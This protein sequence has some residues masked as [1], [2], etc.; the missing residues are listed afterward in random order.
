MFFETCFCKISTY[1]FVFWHNSMTWN[2][3]TIYTCASM[4]RICYARISGH[5]CHLSLNGAHFCPKLWFSLLH[6]CGIVVRHMT[7][8]PAHHDMCD[9][10]FDLQG[11]HKK[12]WQ[13][14]EKWSNLMLLKAPGC[15]CVCVCVFFFF[16]PFYFFNLSRHSAG[17]S[18]YSCLLF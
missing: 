18:I 9:F 6:E 5:W 8:L 3:S 7:C 11:H 15:F 17:W 14:S 1:Y 12:C 10:N 4:G 13:K 16:G 2:A